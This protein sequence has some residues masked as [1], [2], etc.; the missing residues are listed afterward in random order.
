[1]RPRRRGSDDAHGGEIE[2]ALLAVLELL[3]EDPTVDDWAL[4]E[5]LQWRGVDALT[6]MRVVSFGPVA[7]DRVVLERHGLTCDAALA[8]PSH[9]SVSEQLLRLADEAAFTAVKAAVDGL[10]VQD[11]AASA[12][13][14]RNRDAACIQEVSTDGSLDAVRAWSRVV[15]DDWEH[16]TAG[17]L[18]CWDFTFLASDD[19]GHVAEFFTGEAGPI[20]QRVLDRWPA[21]D[22]AVA[23]VERLAVC[24]GPVDS[25]DVA[26]WTSVERGLFAFS[27]GEKPGGAYERVAVPRDP[28]TLDALLRHDAPAEGILSLPVRFAVVDQINLARVGVTLAD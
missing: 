13:L 10:D 18:Q 20:P 23:A 27:W 16:L 11:A 17:V 19:D 9:R 8:A 15:D 24:T 14:D 3:D 4:V 28:V 12:L 5:A 1:M 22:A 6:A 2:T 21:K 25:P 7:F 26:R